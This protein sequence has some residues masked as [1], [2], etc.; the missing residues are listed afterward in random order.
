MRF[1]LALCL[2]FGLAACV[3]EAEPEA[4]VLRPVS[5]D[6]D[7][8][9]SR[10]DARSLDAA[11]DRLNAAGYRADV[12]VRDAT[13]G[14]P[15]SGDTLFAKTIEVSDGV[16]RVLSQRG[17]APAGDEDRRLTAF[18]PVARLLPK[19]P[20]F[21][22]P[23]TRELYVAESTRLRDSSVVI[24]KAD[25]SDESDPIRRVAVSI[26][27]TTGQVVE[28]QVIRTSESAVYDEL[29]NAYVRLR[30]LGG[31]WVPAEGELLSEIDVPLSDA[32]RLLIAWRVQSVGGVE[33]ARE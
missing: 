7:S 19:E 16:V 10:L 29:S 2:A 30:P 9:L 18:D 14:Q 33:L 17:E 31:V 3:P 1:S 15:T 27:T 12:T 24:V 11:F 25:L 13:L 21:R 23:A 22:N 28:A 8:L 20:P 6:P 32:H 4:Y 26:D 5:S